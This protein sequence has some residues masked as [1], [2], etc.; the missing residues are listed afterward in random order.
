[1]ALEAVTGGGCEGCARRAQTP[2][3]HSSLCGKAD[4]ALVLSPVFTPVFPSDSQEGDAVVSRSVP[5]QMVPD[6]ELRMVQDQVLSFTGL[7]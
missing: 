3:G 2:R 5:S 6:S 4:K 1:M 7:G